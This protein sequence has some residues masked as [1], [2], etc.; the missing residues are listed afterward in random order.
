MVIFSDVHNFIFIYVEPQ[1]IF[2]SQVIWYCK[3]TQLFLIVVSCLWMFKM[4]YSWVSVLLSNCVRKLLV[5]R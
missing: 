5:I 1:L 4:I 3:V 2:P